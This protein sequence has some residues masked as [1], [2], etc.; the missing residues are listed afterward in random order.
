MMQVARLA[1]AGL[2]EEAVYVAMTGVYLG[3]AS[4]ASFSWAMAK[5][6]LG[7]LDCDGSSNVTAVA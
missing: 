3:L 5:T 6:M 4:G 7:S 1:P 2:G